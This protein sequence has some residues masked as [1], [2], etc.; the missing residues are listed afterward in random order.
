[1]FR[2]EADAESFAVNRVSRQRRVPGIE[3]SEALVGDHK[4]LIEPLMAFV[5][6][7]GRLPVDGELPAAPQLTAVFGSVARA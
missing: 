2:D 5:T 1:M 3:K 4:E 6:D 7:R